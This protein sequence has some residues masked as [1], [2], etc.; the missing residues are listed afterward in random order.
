MDAVTYYAEI[1]AVLLQL[2]ES[3]QRISQIEDGTY[4]VRRLVI[5]GETIHRCA[6]RLV[7]IANRRLAKN[8]EEEMRSLREAIAHAGR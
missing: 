4:D 8:I 3:I 1:G 7:E 2:D 6:N 5:E